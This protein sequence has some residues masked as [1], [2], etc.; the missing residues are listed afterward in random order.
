MAQ[1]S[2]WMLHS[3]QHSTGF[4]LHSSNFALRHS[5]SH[6]KEPYAWSGPDTI[7]QGAP[8]L[9][10]SFLDTRILA[11]CANHTLDQLLHSELLPWLFSGPPAFSYAVGQPA[12]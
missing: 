11:Y 3:P 6:D 2:I 4:V 10:L 8:S 1:V 12:H 9:L 5:A 7:Q